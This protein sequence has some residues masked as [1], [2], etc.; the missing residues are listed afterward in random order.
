MCV[1]VLSVQG[2]VQSGIR[3]AVRIAQGSEVS[4]R[5]CCELNGCYEFMVAMV[6]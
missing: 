2:Q 1:G 4:A 6:T 5:G 3:N